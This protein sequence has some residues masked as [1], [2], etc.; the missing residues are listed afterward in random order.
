MKKRNLLFLVLG[1]PMVAFGQTK[2]ERERIA[3]FSNKEGNAKLA[4]ELKQEDNQRKQRLSNYFAANPFAKKIIN[5]SVKGKLEI[6]DVLPNGEF[7]YARIDNDGAAITARAKDLYNGGSLGLNIQ[8]QNMIAGVWDEG[9][10]RATHQEFMVNGSSKVTNFNAGATSDHSTHVAGT[11]AAQGITASARGLAFQASINSWNWTNDITEMLAAASNSGLL[12]SNHSYGIGSLNSLW[13]YGAYDSRAKQI[14]ELCYNNPYYLPVFSA[15]NDR[16]S[17]E[18]PGSTQIAT[19]Q[20]YDMIF[21]HANAKNVITVAAIN[22]M[23]N[24]IGLASPQMSQFSSYGPSDD[25]RIKPDI[26]MKGVN[27]YST[28]NT[29]DTA[30]VNMS[31]TSMASPGITGVVALLQQ[32]YNQLYSNFMRAA[33]VKGLILHT[34]DDAG[35]TVGPDARF[36]WGVVNAS[37]SAKVI[38]DKNLGVGG[39]LIEENTLQSEGAYSKTFTASGSGQLRVSISWTDPASLSYNS[40]TTDPATADPQYSNLVN[41]LDITITDSNNV[42]YY[43][44][45]LQGMANYNAPATNNSTNTKDNFERI[46]INNPTG[47][48][49]VSVTHKGVLLSPQNYSLIIT[50]GNLVTLGVQEENITK[51]RVFPNPA[52]DYLI[53]DGTDNFRFSVLDESGRI[54]LKEKKSNNK[55]N[56]SNLIPGVYYLVL[57]NLSGESKTFKFIK[58]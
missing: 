5:D 6:M 27:V 24:Y 43:P 17:T 45:K 25:G 51:I 40:G 53:I 37:T 41:D 7:I 23:N 12:M 57:N 49:T 56:V 9:P 13:F 44:W 8:G 48:Y 34:A 4:L 54:L 36:G 42:V 28:T 47:Q 14:D 20:G 46:D 2:E 39:S 50:A 3:S 38:R 33:T 1:L 58:N 21:G 55:I 31:G 29:G 19:K 11:I 10:V 15:G 26:S 32:Y 35:L 16:N 52:T 18:A 22:Q 30:Y